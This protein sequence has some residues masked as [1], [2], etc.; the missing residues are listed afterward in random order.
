VVVGRTAV[1]VVVAAEDAGEAEAAVVEE[2]L[3]SSPAQCNGPNRRDR[4]GESD[5]AA[6]KHR[7]FSDGNGVRG[8][9]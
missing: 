1:V 3:V 4:W 5:G 6:T 2:G 8:W 7:T 9:S